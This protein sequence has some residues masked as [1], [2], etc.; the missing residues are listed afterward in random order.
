M[1]Y[2]LTAFGDMWV[3][4]AFYTQSWLQSNSESVQVN[5]FIT[6]P[7]VMFWLQLLVWQ[8]TSKLKKRARKVCVGM[9]FCI[10]L[11]FPWKPHKTPSTIN[12]SLPLCSSVAYHHN[13]NFT[14]SLWPK[15]FNFPT[16]WSIFSQRPFNIVSWHSWAVTPGGACAE[17]MSSDQFICL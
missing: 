4:R 17:I 9:P 1:S 16:L 6:K 8:R 3:F 7:Q 13:A 2:I 5:W 15:L 10:F 12:K 11:E 14:L